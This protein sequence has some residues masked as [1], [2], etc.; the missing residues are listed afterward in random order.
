MTMQ[1]IK[2]NN[3]LMVV[4][5]L[6]LAHTEHV[7]LHLP[8]SVLTRW[9]RSLKDIKNIPFRFSGVDDCWETYPSALR[10]TNH[11]DSS[12]IWE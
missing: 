6:L 4:L 3:I 10:D 7:L 12:A 8:T 9:Q 11:M 5:L 2:I 1:K